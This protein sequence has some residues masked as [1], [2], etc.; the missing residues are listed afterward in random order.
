[1]NT[2]TVL[3]KYIAC[4]QS[5]D[6]VALADLAGQL[7][8]PLVQRALAFARAIAD[9]GDRSRALA[10]LAP[11]LPEDGREAT[12][13]AAFADA[14]RYG[15]SDDRSQALIALARRRIESLVARDIMNPTRTR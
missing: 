4:M 7:T 5:G 11:H 9:E 12:L 6:N 15:D 13:E 10:A 2:R 1:M 3:E 14:L 8:G